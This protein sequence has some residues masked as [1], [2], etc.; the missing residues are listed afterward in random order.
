MKKVLCNAL[1]EAKMPIM[2]Q[3]LGHYVHKLGLFEH[4]Q[5]ALIASN[6]LTKVLNRQ[7]ELI[8]WVDNYS[9]DVVYVPESEIIEYHENLEDFL[10]NDCHAVFFADKK[11]VDELQKIVAETQKEISELNLNKQ[12]GASTFGG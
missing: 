8:S 4:E 1:Y 5:D 12:N 2:Y 9:I 6:V 3:E 11:G 7:R 10:V